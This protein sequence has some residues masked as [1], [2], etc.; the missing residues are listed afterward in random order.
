M[1]GPRPHVLLTPPLVVGIICR[2]YVGEKME[3][4]GTTACYFSRSWYFRIQVKREF[5]FWNKT[6]GLTVLATE[7]KFDYLHNKQGAI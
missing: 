4:C 7:L 3:P 2:Q 5:S 1:V 6:V